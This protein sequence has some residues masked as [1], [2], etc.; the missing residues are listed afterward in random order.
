MQTDDRRLQRVAGRPATGSVAEFLGDLA[1]LLRPAALKRA[2]SGF[3][4]NDGL[5]LA[6][7]LAYYMVL[8]LFPLVLVLVSVMGT[9]SSPQLAESLL[10]Y[11]REV[12]PAEVYALIE[13]YMADVL[14]GRNPAPGLLSFGILGTLWAAS[15]ALS[16]LINALNRI[17]GIRETRPFWKVK[18]L[19]ILLT[20]GLSGLVFLGVFLLVLGPHLGTAVAE[21]FGLGSLFEMVW[22]V[23]RWPVALVFLMVAVVLIYYLAPDAG[24]PFRWITPGGFAGVLL[25]VLASLA[26]S[27][28]VGNF[29]AYD[30]TYGSIGAVIVLLLYLYISSLTILLG[31]ELNAALLRTKEEVSG[32]RILQGE[33]LGTGR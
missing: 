28:Y 29:G 12:L 6:A 26:F 27:F 32:E 8:A 19:A 1:A 24:Q 30:A 23:V 15:G 17:Y 3:V 18:G 14:G 22:H 25:W 21:F 4:S 33:P 31:A 11:F 16:A 2:F 20:L 10:E 13:S 7:Q 5:G 9:F